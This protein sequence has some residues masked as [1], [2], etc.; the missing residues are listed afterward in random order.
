MLARLAVLLQN[1]ELQGIE[2]ITGQGFGGEG[3]T[4]VV[5]ENCSV[6]TRSCSHG[7][8]TDILDIRLCEAVIQRS[9]KRKPDV[10]LNEHHYI[11]RL[12]FK[13][14]HTIHKS[15]GPKLSSFFFSLQIEAMYILC[16][17]MKMT[18]QD[19]PLAHFTSPQR[20]G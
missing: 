2:A 3:G 7:S 19:F 11:Q 15:Y 16:T 13:Y 14:S 9:S 17:T 18:S 8:D 6:C 4:I 20:R 12:I 10:K 5:D 1:G